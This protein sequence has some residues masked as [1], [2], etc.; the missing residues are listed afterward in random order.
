MNILDK[1]ESETGAGLV[2]RL[3]P[4]PRVARLSP[5]LSEVQLESR[6]EVI[7]VSGA[8]G[9]GKSLLLSEWIAD[10]LVHHG[11]EDDAAAATSGVLLITLE[12]PS[13]VVENLQGCLKKRLRKAKKDM[14]NSQCDVNSAA[15][16]LRCDPCDDVITEDMLHAYMDRCYVIAVFDET[17]FE[18]AVLSLPFALNASRN[19]RGCDISM[20][21]VDNIGTGYEEARQEQGGLA[22]HRFV[23]QRL[24]N[25]TKAISGQAAGISLVFTKTDLS[26][27]M[28]APSDGNKGAR[29]RSRQ[30]DARVTLSVTLVASEEGGATSRRKVF[31]NLE[32][33]AQ[34]TRKTL[35]MDELGLFKE[36]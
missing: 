7:Q 35:V 12:H 29:R 25:L 21:V 31:A 18:L 6:G 23:G 1:V 10:V 32:T 30:W 22:F 26:A 20:V 8:A 24:A 33:A 9:V 19:G 4:R 5:L 27:S 13:V 15:D 2:E 36:V 28:M 17:E 14:T 11:G 3:C 16:L 34:E